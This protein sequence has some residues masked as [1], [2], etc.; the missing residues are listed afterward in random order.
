MRSSRRSRT[1]LAAG[2]LA[3]AAASA[4]AR[5]GAT[6][7]D[8]KTFF[9]Q[10]RKL[11]AEHRCTDAIIAFR[12]ALDLYPQGLGALRNIA[13]C[14]EELGLY[15]SAR[16]NWWS[17]RRAVLQSNEPKYDG[18][19]SDA[20]Q[21]YNRL[22]SKVARVTVKLHGKSLDRAQVSIDGKP[23]DPRLVGVEIERDLGSHMIEASYGG[24]APVQKK[25]ELAPGQRLEVTLEIPEAKP[26]EK[27]RPAQAP[28]PAEGGGGL[29]TAG[30]AALTVGGA[31]LVGTVVSALVRGNALSTID[32]LCP[33]RVN[34]PTSLEEDERR[35]RTAATLVNVFGAVTIVGVGVG[36]PLLVLSGKSGAA[37][38]GEQ[39]RKAGWQVE[40]APLPEGAAARVQG[41]F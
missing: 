1:W 25:I 22:E 17:L 29:R 11:R 18:W 31:G 7:E 5:A 8:A 10:G 15:A 35:G 21:A 12:R 26:A 4:P 23:L 3:L 33:A 40:I 39:G 9:A 24:A 36:V 16:N 19:D 32:E 14:E 6:E 37:K 30:I 38:P 2:L 27:P 20:E 28:P 41:R 34:C 13:E